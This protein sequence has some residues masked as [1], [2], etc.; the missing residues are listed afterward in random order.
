MKSPVLHLQKK[1]LNYQF[2]RLTTFLMLLFFNIVFS[3]EQKL[4]VTPIS[5]QK[6]EADLFVGY[7]GLENVYYIKDNVFYKKKETQIWQYKNLSLGK[8]TRIDIQNPLNIVLYYEDFN[9]V[10]LLDNQLNETQKINFSK[11]DIPIIATAIGIASQNRLWI[12]NSLSQQIGV[13]NYLKKS[14]QTLTTS[15]QDAIIYYESDFNTFHWIDEKLNWHST[16]VYGEITDL[17]KVVEFDQIKILNSHSVLFSKGEKIYLQD[18]K[19]GQKYAIENVEKS[20]KKIYYRDQIL[21][22]FTNSGIS[23]YKIIVP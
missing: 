16:T 13:F 8:I 22:I 9:T 14:F 15:L 1:S 11:N 18:F 5:I 6:I 17:G 2:G 12:Y 19:S 10:V 7:D 4:L 3:Q 23:N 21:S 20:F